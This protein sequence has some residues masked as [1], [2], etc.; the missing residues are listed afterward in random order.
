M[1]YNSDEL[2]FYGNKLGEYLIEWC[3]STKSEFPI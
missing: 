3:N 2:G 1:R